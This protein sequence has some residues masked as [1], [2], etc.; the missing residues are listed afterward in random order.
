M[1]FRSGFSHFAEL[2][3]AVPFINTRYCVHALLN[4]LDSFT[5]EGQKKKVHVL[6]ARKSQLTGKSYL[7]LE[8]DKEADTGPL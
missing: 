2:I 8:Y 7:G 6:L 1:F 4:D 5:G 3:C